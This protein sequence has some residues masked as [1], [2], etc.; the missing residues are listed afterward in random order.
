MFQNTNKV[1]SQNSQG[2]LQALIEE[3]DNAAGE[4]SNIMVL[5]FHIYYKTNLIR[6]IFYYKKDHSWLLTHRENKQLIKKVGAI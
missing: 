3:I 1:G 6:I 5:L 2:M 4:S